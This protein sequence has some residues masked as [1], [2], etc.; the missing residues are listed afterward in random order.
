ML[1]KRQQA[2][3]YARKSTRKVK[4]PE[5]AL[6]KF[7]DD[8][9]AAK[10]LSYIRLPDRLWGVLHR[11]LSKT[12]P[13]VLWGLRKALGGLPDNTVFIPIND[14]Y[15]L[16]LH[17]ELKTKSGLHG[18]QKVQARELPWQIAQ[19]P[20]DVQQIVDRFIEDAEDMK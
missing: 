12:Y 14:R 18:Q 19:T 8:Y 3:R 9:L 4:M 20:E 15:S 16:A 2:G 5:A 13:G 17:L 6:Q 10:G 11:A 7:T 1:T